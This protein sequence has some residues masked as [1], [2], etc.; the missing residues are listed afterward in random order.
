MLA[1]RAEDAEG[2]HQRLS[3]PVMRRPGTAVD[4]TRWPHPAA[5]FSQLSLTVETVPDEEGSPWSEIRL[6]MA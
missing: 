3:H 5:A 4:Q 2:Q 6:D 1:D